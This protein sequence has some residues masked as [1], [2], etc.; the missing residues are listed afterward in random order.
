MAAKIEFT[1]TH[2]IVDRKRV[3][4]SYCGPNNWVDG[5]DPTTIKIRP[6][7]GKSHFPAEVR[8]AFAIENNS[9]AMTDYFEADSIRLV[10]S[11]PLYAAVLAV[12]GE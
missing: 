2:M 9:D 7:V 1:A 4:V 12:T 6:W 5:V 10:S 3:R 8:A 11:H